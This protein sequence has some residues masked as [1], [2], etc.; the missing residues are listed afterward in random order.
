M[1]SCMKKAEQWL[2]KKIN[3]VDGR[4]LHSLKRR[5]NNEKEKAE[6][7][8]MLQVKAGELTN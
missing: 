7:T 4:K 5:R 8:K 2:K 3:A 6:E 1:K